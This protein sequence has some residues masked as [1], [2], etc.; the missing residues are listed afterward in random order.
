MAFA[1]RPADCLRGTPADPPRTPAYSAILASLKDHPLPP[2]SPRPTID[3][4]KSALRRSRGLLIFASL[5]TLFLYTF[6]FLDGPVGLGID[7]YWQQW[8][9]G[10]RVL[11]E[12]PEYCY[13]PYRLPGY[14]ERSELPE[15]PIS[16]VT[17][18]ASNPGA[19]GR[20]ARPSG[21]DGQAA[22][23]VPT[24]SARL[25]ADPGA[26]ELGF[27]RNRTVLFVGDSLDRNAVYHLAQE[28]FGPGAHRFLG[29]QDAPE[30]AAPA[31]DSHRIGLGVH[32]G[33]GFTVANWF[34]MSVDIDRPSTPFFHAGEDPPQLF[35]GRFETF[36]EPLLRTQPPLI[37]PPDMVVFNSGLWDLVFLSNLKDHQIAQNRS[38]GIMSP[39]QVTGKELLGPAEI[40]RHS[41]RFNAFLDK[42]LFH[43][44]N[45][46]LPAK[47][48]RFVYRT[49]PDSSLVLAKDNAMS[50]KRVR[51]IDA[52]NLRLIHAFNARQLAHKGPTQRTLID[53]LD[54][55][56]V[57]SQLLDEL[58]DLVHFGRGATQWLYGDMV[59]HHLRRH[60]VG[61][62]LAAGFRIR[63]AAPA[64]SA[65][66]LRRALV[67]R[68][69]RRFGR[70][71]LS[72][73]RSGTA[74]GPRLSRSLF[75]P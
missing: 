71:V 25:L 63:G 72:L 53:V 65:D 5:A 69:C 38:Q 59:L 11:E 20:L 4:L 30:A 70:L 7:A 32:P 18:I 42:L 35:E 39:L 37:P 8:A 6:S 15:G 57:S 48:T 55:T 27:L 50:R 13:D 60:V 66:Q 40:A 29:P 10:R 24:L 62:E 45:H 16:S 64:P 52:L 14:V 36:Y 21:E 12:L 58:I 41:A 51:Q 33:L 54:W 28:T 34:L 3:L 22:F 67:W 73:N 19:K 46:T 17:W 31:H 26:D 68:D 9:P 23:V 1:E 43:T 2:R 47:P 74:R 61:Q 75:N 44:F 56:W 49:M